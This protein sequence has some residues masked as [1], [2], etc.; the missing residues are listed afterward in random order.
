MKYLYSPL[1]FLKFVK[2]L[3]MSPPPP[4]AA[5]T[6]SRLTPL[7]LRSLHYYLRIYTS[8]EMKKKNPET[9]PVNDG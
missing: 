2:I 5:K 1:L 7:N 4:Q 3:Q 6:L 8:M 9:Y